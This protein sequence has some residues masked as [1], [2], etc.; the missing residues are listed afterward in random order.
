VSKFP[1]ATRNHHDT[2]CVTEKWMLVRGA[3]GQPVSHHR[4]YELS[5][6]D[7]RILRTR[8]SKPVNKD[9]YAAST[10]SH[11]LRDQLDVVAEVFWA[12]VTRG[13]LPARGQR[14]QP[15]KSLPLYLVNIL[16]TELQLAPERIAEMTDADAEQAVA[17]HWARQKGASAT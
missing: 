15:Q 11:I 14:A 4:T 13:E 7:G 12:C 16:T 6:A 17:E 1:A 3:S 10:W 8:I 2:F 5:L 9:T